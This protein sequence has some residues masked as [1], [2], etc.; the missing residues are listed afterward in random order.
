MATVTAE[1]RR[2]EGST[3]DVVAVLAD[4]VAQ[5]LRRSDMQVDVD[6]PLTSLG[7]DSLKATE[8]K[9]MLEEQFGVEL[10][11][12]RL[13]DGLTISELA[14][15]IQDGSLVTIP[16]AAKDGGLTAT[17]AAEVPPRVANAEELAIATAS[18]PTRAATVRCAMQFSLFFFASDAQQME[19]NRY[20]LLLESAAFADRN[21]F[22]AVW[23]PERHFH[24]FG[25]LFPNPSVLGAALAAT[26]KRVRIRAGSV[27]LPL[28]DPV[29][30][31]EEWSVVDNL[32]DGRVDVA[33]A[34]GWNA[35]DFVFFPDNY[36]GREQVL[37][38]G[39]Q[40][41]Q[42]LWKGSP[43]TRANGKG[44]PIELQILPRPVQPQ[45]PTWIT[46]SGGIER[47]R[48]AGAIGANVITALLFQDVEQLTEKLEAYR[49]ARAAHGFDPDTGHVTLMLHTH[50]GADEGTVRRA[51]EAPFKQYLADSVDLWRRGSVALHELSDRERES[52]L[53]FAFERYYRTS[54]LFGTPDSTAAM[55]QQL[56]DAGVDEIACLIDFGLTDQQVLDGLAPLDALRARFL[57]D[58]NAAMAPVGAVAPERTRAQK[59]MPG[60][61]DAVNG[62][63]AL[64]HRNRGGVLAKVKEFDL[65][66]RLR[67]AE[68]L[69]FYVELT[70]NEGAT[71]LYQGRQLVMMGSNNY[72]GLTTDERVRQAVA[73]A[74][75]TD[76]PSL[77]GS[78]LLNGSTSAQVAFER[79]L[80]DFLGRQDSLLFTT[81]YQ[82]NI[83]LLSALMG[84]ETLLIVDEEGH[85]SIYDGAAV[86]RCAVVQFHHNDVTD[87]E[88]QLRDNAGRPTMV[89]VDGVYS[90][91]G[92]VA[93][94]PELERLCAA[95]GVPLAVDD[96]HG[97]G[98]V[99]ATGRGVEELLGVLGCAE[100]LT[101]TFSKSLA[102]IGGWVAGDRDLVEWVRYHGRSAVFSAAIPPTALAAASTAL[103]VLIAEPWRMGRIREN[104][105]YWRA[106]LTGLGFQIGNSQTAIVPVIVGDELQCLRFARALLDDG[107]YANCIVAPA[108]PAERALIRTSIMATHERDHLDRGLEIF[109]RAGRQLGLIA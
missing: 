100:V 9:V 106:G 26:T 82:A 64:A 4:W 93:P 49:Q 86:G 36:A 18:A 89:M 76:G 28:H 83:G 79:Q 13:F 55:V 108:V 31:A 25:G 105:D 30:V 50:I 98:M 7:L 80:A 10:S 74:A 35:D 65:P 32:S 46:C 6:R 56:R 41:V 24:A 92:D 53:A 42:A 71:C 109:A 60:L 45:L 27:V 23:T 97:L 39:V 78:R 20:H 2:G 104:A 57:V 69:P 38:D 17:I 62:R 40:T 51:V 14:T 103:D 8:F 3:G 29:R 70:R 95:Y 96:A 11:L 58:E 34:V 72:L 91:S 47:F 90:M 102:S 101:G 63:H 67:S 1:A 21:D 73:T 5:Q 54:A 81:G 68:L 48:Q 37:L 85:A 22:V 66:E 84:E 59:S 77:T 15:A 52:V 99:G 61:V 19:S 107:L 12:E 87:L 44:E 33:F 16:T 43:L 94:L 75:L 88:R